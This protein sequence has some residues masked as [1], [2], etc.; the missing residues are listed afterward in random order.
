MNLSGPKTKLLIKSLLFILLVKTLDVFLFSY[1]FF[2]FPNELEWDTS[3]WYNFLEKT[4]SI[5]FKK[6]EK[7]ILVSGSSVAMYSILPP[8]L[9]S[10]LNKEGSKYKTEFYSHVAMSPTDLYYY[11]EDIQ[12]KN[13]SVLLYLV[14]PG[15]FQLDHFVR[16]KGRTDYQYSESERL[17]AYANRHP[18]RVVYPFS[19]LLDNFL[20]LSKIEK[21]HLATKSILYI[22]RYRGFIYDPIEAFIER[23]Y[24]SSRSYHNYT[25]ALPDTGIW[26]KGWTKETF[27]I[28]CELREK[29]KFKEA[30]FIPA[31]GTSVKIFSGDTLLHAEGYKKSGWHNLT[32]SVPLP[33]G[34]LPLRFEITPSTSSKAIDPKLRGKEYYYGMRVS[35]NFCK[36]NFERDISYTRRENLDDTE[37]SLMSAEEY[38]KD[39]FARMYEDAD[40]PEKRPEVQRLYYIHKVKKFLGTNN[41]PLWSEF[42]Y[43]KK[44]IENLKKNDITVIIVNNPENP[45]ELSLYREGEWYKKYLA[46][47][48]D[49]ESKQGVRFYD[50]KDFISDPRMFIDSHHLTYIG[51]KKMTEEYAS[52]LKDALSSQ[53]K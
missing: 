7:G 19:F 23:H 43:L 15:D 36:K 38:E 12:S 14:N 24:R 31:I 26:R 35:Q 25:G 29:G 20:S 11:S 8:D 45:Y 50:R 28:N 1:L 3:P 13:P 42:Q 39:Y 27:T 10:I 30:V 40:F 51:S 37:L 49:L 53:K 33:V 5:S 9:D 18:V 16:E 21:I 52:I 17:K 41:P 2:K 34:E 44:A 47:L 4:K 6:E 22:N 32:F 46:F 48:K